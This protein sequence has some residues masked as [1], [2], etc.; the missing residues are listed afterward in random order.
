[1]TPAEFVKQAN[2][3]CERANREREVVAAAVP[4]NPSPA[5]IRR[6][7]FQHEI[8]NLRRQIRGIGA[9]PAPPA[10]RAMVRRFVT[11]GEEAVERLRARPQ[12]VRTLVDVFWTPL[13]IA[14]KMGLA[15]CG[16]A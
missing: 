12:L 11:T 16:A 14:R 5:E 13:K 2:A 8:P 3:I 6:Y 1:L 15:S 7:V 4:K 9:L 10:D